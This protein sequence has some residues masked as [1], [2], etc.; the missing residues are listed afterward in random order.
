MSNSNV[1]NA[2]SK[3]L[4]TTCLIFFVVSLLFAGAFSHVLAGGKQLLT[5]MK[6]GNREIEE[7]LALAEF[8]Q[9]F[10][11]RVQA[12]VAAYQ[13]HELL[14]QKIRD[15][16]AGKKINAFLKAIDS[17]ESNGYD[18]RELL[19]SFLIQKKQLF[20]GRALGSISGSVKVGDTLSS[21]N[22][23]EVLA[24][25]KY[26]FFAGIASADPSTGGYTIKDLP[27]GDYYLV[28]QG[29]FV[30]EFHSE[31]SDATLDF[32]GSWKRADLVS[33]RDGGEVIG[34][35]FDLASGT[36]NIARITDL[37]AALTPGTSNIQGTVTGPDEGP[38][39]LGIVFAF[40]LADTSVAGVAISIVGG[41]GSFGFYSVEDLAAGTYKVYADSYF[42]LVIRLNFMG[43]PVTIKTQSL[44]GEYYQD[45]RTSQDATALTL[46]ETDTLRDI[47]FTLELG[48]A[49][50]GN[51]K[52]NT[53]APVDSIFV[54]AIK[55]VTLEDV[56]KF[57][58]D[59]IDFGIS[60]S[61]A[62]G[63]YTIAGLSPGDYYLRTFS[64][65]SPE[66]RVVLGDT[67]QLEEVEIKV[68]KHFGRVVNEY[69][70]NVQSIF[71]LTDA[72]PVPVSGSETT[73]GIDFVL[74]LAGA[75]SGRFVEA[76]DGVTPI[77]GQGIVIAFDAVT[78]L[79]ELAL[80]I[81]DTLDGSYEIRPL[82]T[83][84]FKLLGIVVN[85]D[86][87]VYVPQFFDGKA[88]FEEA[89][90]VHVDA[91]NLTSNKDFKMVRAGAIAGVVTLPSG[92]S[93]A[94][95][96]QEPQITVLVFNADDGEL[97]GGSDADPFSGEYAID[98]LPPRDY[99][100]VALAA[101]QG[102]AAT[103][104]DG[105]T[106]FDAA[107]SVSVLSDQTTTAN[108]QMATGEGIISGMVYNADGTIPLPG[109]LIIV[110]DQ[111]GHVVSV[112]ISGLDMNTGDP[113]QN[114]GEYH[115]PGL[116]AGSYYVRAFPLF[117]LF[118]MI[119][120]TGASGNMGGD[121]LSTSFGLLDSGEN[122]QGP[123]DIELFADVW[124][125]DEVD[126]VDLQDLDLFSLLL[127]LILSEG[128]PFSLIPFFDLPPSVS[129]TIP[130][131][132]ASAELVPVES[133]GETPAIDF[134]L[135]PLITDV[136][137]GPE[138]ELVPKSFQLSQNFPNPFNPSTKITYGVP[139]A[140]Q[141][142]LH[143]YNLLGQ[144]IRILFDAKRAAGTYTTHWD[145]L[146]DKGEHVAAGIYF[147]RMET[148]GLALTRK[149]LLVR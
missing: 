28:T 58:T 59:D 131:L 40:D 140:A 74:D 26:G 79:P 60:F 117:Q 32:S 66:V 145:G 23:I 11:E 53:S 12:K 106:T 80:A 113:L 33:V 51:I 61:D 84:D 77:V 95:A 24:F 50:S 75:I 27:A 47:N 143:I 25:D 126:P 18:T 9:E 146:N 49:I 2:T 35:N 78:G 142:K 57:F 121:P 46:A 70:D 39:L 55:V 111:T 4:V 115:V 73:P 118:L 16:P 109:V 92:S 144:R 147:L 137:E 123:L 64:F 133:P 65:I 67:L 7:K 52:D 110:Y 63:N 71:R 43:F 34:V 134:N 22:F 17:A 122:L 102:I 42:E 107:T 93:L 125:P 38:V 87:V 99:K 129:Q 72:T 83:G 69:Y 136:E 20:K 138:T 114:P 41:L 13:H 45:A 89:T 90:V 148:D 29:S 149:M 76:T 62:Q 139:K 86:G 14:L 19:Q 48:G 5:E 37:K 6:I 44:L 120:G 88:S 112:G 108:I 68:G 82:P 105:A 100:V 94:G 1:T 56:T 81:S 127:R 3:I 15:Y 132:S 30:D 21:S 116:A 98:G 128:D 54:I 97:A 101:T 36:K 141:V 85:S 10:I 91:P 96:V 103:Y 104:H 124:Y 8:N 119:G 130:L 135:P 31:K